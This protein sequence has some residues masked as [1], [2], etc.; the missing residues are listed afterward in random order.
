[1]IKLCWMR[2]LYGNVDEYFF[3]PEQKTVYCIDLSDYNKTKIKFTPEAAILVAGPVTTFIQI[4]LKDK[5]LIP[6]FL[7]RISVMICLAAGSI[8][9]NIFYKKSEARKAEYIRTHATGMQRSKSQ[10]LSLLKSGK[11][12]RMGISFFVL[13]CL[14]MIFLSI[15]I[16][17]SDKSAVAVAMF[18]VSFY[19]GII[20]L[21]I[22][23]P[24]QIHTLK[25]YLDDGTN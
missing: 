25:R 11:K 4:M 17:K 12:Y 24:I 23:A 16:Y 1:M 21:E 6:D 5:I 20:W 22:L 15:I 7:L 18:C 3:D 14:L 8:L 10:V 2:N 13:I 9:I 19:T